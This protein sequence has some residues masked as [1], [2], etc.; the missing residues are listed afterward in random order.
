[1]QGIIWY[2]IMNLLYMLFPLLWDY[3][4]IQFFPFC[5][6]WKGRKSTKW[7]CWGTCWF[8]ENY[9]SSIFMR[10]AQ[11][12]CSETEIRRTVEQEKCDKTQNW[13]FS[14]PAKLSLILL[15]WGLVVDQILSYDKTVGTVEDLWYKSG[16][17]LY[18]FLDGVCF[19]EVLIFFFPWLYWPKRRKGA[20][21]LLPDQ[22]GFIKNIHS[23]YGHSSQQ[24][25]ITSV[26]NIWNK[27]WLYLHKY[28]DFV[29]HM[30]FACNTVHLFWF[31]QK[32]CT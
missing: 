30:M 3:L 25:Q 2:N 19:D 8:L 16:N 13:W 24:Q 5:S 17:R 14:D 9:F 29:I 4:F 23:V 15:P 12:Y 21:V 7:F 10:H 18:Q 6:L 28:E 31:S 26:R 20:K 11:C 22:K 1:M 32:L 27:R